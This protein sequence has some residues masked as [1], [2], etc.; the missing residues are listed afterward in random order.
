NCASAAHDVLGVLGIRA[1]EGHFGDFVSFGG[2]ALG[3]AKGLEGFH[4][5]GLDAIG[6]ADFQTAVTALDDAGVDVRELGK[7]G[8]GE[9]ARR[10]GT[11]DQY[12]DFLGEF[13]RAVNADS[14]G[15]FNTRVTGNVT[16]VVELH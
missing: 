10:S 4:A 9:H 13:L 11:D 16:V 7:L 15:W 14:G 3:E 6:L 5:A 12:V 8:R 1:P 2:D